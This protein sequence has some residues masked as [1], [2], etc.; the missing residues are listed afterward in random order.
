[1]NWHMRPFSN[2]FSNK[3]T[4]IILY[5]GCSVPWG[6]GGGRE[7]G[8]VQY[9]GRYLESRGNIQYRGEIGNCRF[10]DKRT[11]A[12]EFKSKPHILGQNDILG[13]NVVLGQMT[14]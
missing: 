11:H 7:G 2:L 14:F 1:M 13:Q 9:R 6:G 12:H 5:N 8:D 4:K 10:W 3:T